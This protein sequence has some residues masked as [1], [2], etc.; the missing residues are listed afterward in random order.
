MHKY[1]QPNWFPLQQLHFKKTSR[2]KLG[3]PN[4]IKTTLHLWNLNRNHIKIFLQLWEREADYSKEHL[5][6]EQ[7]QYSH[8]SKFER[9]E[10]ELELLSEQPYFGRVNNRSRAN[11]GE[12]AYLPCR[13]K[14]MQD[15]YMVRNEI[16]FGKLVRHFS[17]AARLSSLSFIQ[18]L[19]FLS[20]I[21]P[22]I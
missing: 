14:F 10:H 4:S 2:H 13:V 1:S 19:W 22:T 16:V 20:N 18:L 9:L 11:L 12:V 21:I 3:N 17:L 5:I 15:G 7:Q 6:S 8:E